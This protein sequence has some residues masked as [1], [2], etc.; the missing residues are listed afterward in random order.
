MPVL[1]A[2]MSETKHV[3]LPAAFEKKQ[4]AFYWFSI[5]IA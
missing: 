2:A 5:T 4:L 1:Q 3:G